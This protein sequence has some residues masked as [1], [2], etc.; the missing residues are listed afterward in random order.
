MHSNRINNKK[1][2][3]KIS[4]TK[5]KGKKRKRT[6]RGVTG[7]GGASGESADDGV[8]EKVPAAGRGGGRRRRRRKRSRSRI[9]AQES[10]RCK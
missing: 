5:E 6:V 7:E 1:Y 4:S 2:K 3:M 9:C 10:L 8:F